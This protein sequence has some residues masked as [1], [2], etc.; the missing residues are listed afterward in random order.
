AE[1]SALGE[2]HKLQDDAPGAHVPAVNSIPLSPPLVSLSI[3]HLTLTPHDL[4]STAVEPD[5]APT[6]VEPGDIQGG[7]MSVE[8][9]PGLGPGTQDDNMVIESGQATSLSDARGELTNVSNHSVSTASNSCN[10]IA[11]AHI[12]TPDPAPTPIKPKEVNREKMTMA[13][14]LSDERNKLTDFIAF[15]YFQ[16]N[17]VQSV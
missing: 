14:S 15:Q 5:L 1:S 13:T 11:F 16:F 7:K 3:T 12:S 4:S 10:A 6:L 9:Q 17:H 8:P 2:R